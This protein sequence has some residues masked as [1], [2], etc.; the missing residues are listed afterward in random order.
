MKLVNSS[1]F[2]GRVVHSDG[3]YNRSSIAV[4][5]LMHMQGLFN[6]QGALPA[7]ADMLPTLLNST[8]K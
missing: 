5:M 1:C 8:C 3:C 2:C 4:H 7:C 6:L